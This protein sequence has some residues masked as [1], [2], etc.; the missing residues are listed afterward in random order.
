MLVLA[1][2]NDAVGGVEG[3]AAGL[4]RA[5]EVPEEALQGLGRGAGID[6]VGRDP[7]RR[8]RRPGLAGGK[9]AARPGLRDA[10]RVSLS[11]G[12]ERLFP[13]EP[14]CR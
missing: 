11:G 4:A 6:G 10:G 14:V 3:D 8:G 5:G 9:R 2:F 12:R 1:H 7:D 13:E